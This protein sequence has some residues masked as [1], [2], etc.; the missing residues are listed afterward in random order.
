MDA[1]LLFP[2]IALAGLAIIWIVMHSIDKKSEYAKK[3]GR[4]VK[5]NGCSNIGCIVGLLLFAIGWIVTNLQECSSGS[6]DYNRD[7]NI[8]QPIHRDR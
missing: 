5:E 1:K 4:E 7:I 8:E 6:R 3:E 2:L